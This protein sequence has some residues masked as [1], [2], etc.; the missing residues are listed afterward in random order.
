MRCPRCQT[1]NP[2]GADFCRV[3]RHR[4]FA[5]LGDPFGELEPPEALSE[6]AG[7]A[8]PPVAAVALPAARGF[9]WGKAI[10]AGLLTLMLLA[11]SP[12]WAT[13]GGAAVGF[14]L[15][16]WRRI[17]CALFL[18]LLAAVLLAV[19]VLSELTGV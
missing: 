3:C 6:A 8:K 7:A 11:A 9:P 10:V 15:W 14:V 12:V 1:E 2:P 16:R 5:W 17:G 18:A 13:V 19:S 4:Q